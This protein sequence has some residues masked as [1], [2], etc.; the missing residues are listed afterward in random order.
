M[1]FNSYAKKIFEWV[2]HGSGNSVVHAVAGSG[3]STVLREMLKIIPSSKRILM[4]AFNTSIAG[5]LKEKVKMGNVNISTCHSLGLQY[6]RMYFRNRDEKPSL[7]VDPKKYSSRFHERFEDYSANVERCEDVDIRVEALRTFRTLVMS[8]LDKCR[9]YMCRDTDDVMKVADMYRIFLTETEA[10]CILSLMKWGMENLE[11]IDFTDMI[12]LP[13]YMDM[14]IPQYKYDW[15]LIDECQDLNN[16]MKDL[17]LRSVRQGG[18]FCAVGDRAQAIMS[19]SGANP[20]SFDSLCQIPDTSVFPLSMCYRCPQVIEPVAR[21]YV[22]EF[23]CAENAGRGDVY[24]RYIRETLVVKNEKLFEGYEKP[25]SGF[26]CGRDVSADEIKNCS[27]VLCRLTFPLIKLFRI[28][29]ESKRKAY[30]KGG[31]DIQKRLLILINRTGNENTGHNFDGEGIIPV[32]YREVLELRKEALIRIY[33]KYGESLKYEDALFEAAQEPEVK[34]LYDDIQCLEAIVFNTDIEKKA[35][36]LEAVHNIFDIPEEGICLS[37]VHKAKGLEADDVYILCPSIFDFMEKKPNTEKWEK[38]AEK[39]LQ[40]VAW[41]R[42]KKTLSTISEDEF[43][44]GGGNVIDEMNEHLKVVENML[45]DMARGYR[46]NII[47]GESVQVVKNAYV[48]QEGGIRKNAPIS[49][50]EAKKLRGKSGKQ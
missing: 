34:N 5:E 8:A 44:F 25:D 49:P 12:T 35:E 20:Q 9:A 45:S 37:T 11:T 27:M 26:H 23:E 6:V 13:A 7:R 46:V 30:I 32:L 14:D 17:F 50:K 15:V 42:C 16:A 29:L 3:K 38:E 4:L 33:R 36:L 39:C 19:F 22:P 1:E 40:Y 21:I 31:K 2:E 41:T 47:R 10:V 24:S 48:G 28:F 43:G 18:R